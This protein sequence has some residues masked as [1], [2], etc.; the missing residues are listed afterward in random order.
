[1]STDQFIH[2]EMSLLD[3]NRSIFVCFV[4]ADNRYLQRRKL[5]KDLIGISNNIKHLPWL[6]LGDFNATRYIHEKVGGDT[7]WS[8]IKEEFNSVVVEAELDDLKYG[9]CQ[10]TWANK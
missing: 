10:F 3:E 7:A 2:C 8:C 9:G 5:W 6:V 4:Y 1:M